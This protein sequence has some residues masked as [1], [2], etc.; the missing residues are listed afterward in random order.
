MPAK[1]ETV[2][3]GEACHNCRYYQTYLE[4]EGQT[5]DD[6]E[7]ESDYTGVCRRYP[8]Q[9]FPIYPDS[10]ILYPDVIGATGWCGEYTPK[11]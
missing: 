5:E 7:Q 1:T 3:N 8:P 2:Q 11:L 9:L 4:H 6:P 10:M